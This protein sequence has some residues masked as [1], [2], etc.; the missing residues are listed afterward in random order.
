MAKKQNGFGSPGSFAF[1]GV[2]KRTDKNK[3]QGAFGSYPSNRR[4]STSVQR[5]VIEQY[6]LD[7]DWSRWRKGYEYYNQG[8]YLLFTQLDT[9]MYQGT[10]GMHLGC[11][12]RIPF[13]SETSRCL[14]F[15]V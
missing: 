13:S 14:V 9:V 12:T 15:P 8:A 2:D 3:K 4:Y 7:S 6:N 5:T 10:E 11:N 1:K